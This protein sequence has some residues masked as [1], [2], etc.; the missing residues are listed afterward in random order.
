[1]FPRGKPYL[2]LQKALAGE[3]NPTVSQAIIDQIE[4]RHQLLPSTPQSVTLWRG[5]EALTWMP[6]PEAQSIP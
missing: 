3:M 2:F 4:Q 5:P 6:K 1:M